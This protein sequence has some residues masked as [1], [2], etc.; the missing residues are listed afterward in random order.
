MLK[1][2][3][4]VRQDLKQHGVRAVQAAHSVAEY[5]LQNPDTDWDNGT[6]VLLKVEDEDHLKEYFE[7]LERR[8]IKYTAFQEPDLDNQ[9]TALTA[10]HDNRIPFCGLR[11]L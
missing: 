3:T 2:Y 1:L 11:L 6:M 7:H 9:Y 10:E 8:N 4:L 5:L